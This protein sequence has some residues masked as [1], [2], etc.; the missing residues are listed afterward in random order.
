MIKLASGFALLPFYI[1]AVIEYQGSSFIYTVFTLLM[2][3]M[4]LSGFY[5]KISYGYTFLVVMLWLGFWS[6]ITFHILFDYPYVEPIGYFSGANS[7]WDEVLIVASFGS[8]GVVLARLFFSLI[9]GEGSSIMLRESNFNVPIW[10]QN[11]RPWLW[12]ALVIVFIGLAII[13]LKLGIHQIG[14]TPKT[15]LLWPLNA[16]ISWLLNFG[17]AMCLATLI[18]WDIVIGRNI[19]YV[20]YLVLLEG[21]LFGVSTLSRK[22]FV[23]HVVPQ[24]LSVFYNKSFVIGWTR[25]NVITVCVVFLIF[26]AISHPLIN[27]LRNYHYSGSPMS[28]LAYLPHDSNL[29]G[30]SLF[31]RY[32]S[33]LP[34]DSFLKYFEFVFDG[35]LSFFQFAIDRWIWAEGLMVV[36]AL[37]DKGLEL[38][39]AVLTET[40]EVG[41]VTLY[42]EL[43]QSHYRFADLSKYQFGSTGGVMA[44]FYLI[45]I[46]WLVTIGMIALVTVMLVSEW[47][48]FRVTHN[49]ILCALWGGYSSMSVAAFGN[50]PSS[51]LI[52]LLEM[53]FGFI[54]IWFVQS[55]YLSDVL[56]K[57]NLLA[58]K[59]KIGRG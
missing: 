47:L 58:K 57:C 9:P 30:Y 17:V 44:F 12:S 28:V 6:K 42:Q 4:L 51:L 21:V 26:M 37:P 34:I 49:P 25:K 32:L 39:I 35:L 56:V 10:Y 41:K 24:L 54:A 16:I 2:L 53:I 45:G 33:F 38:F 48:I 18:F 29:P 50:A 1:A 31:H 14:L 55:K 43:S 22:L 27:F 59:V 23:F 36:S 20:V 5:R 3:L 7:E 19:S 40:R 52:Y 15:I 11:A 46:P 8:V 13:N